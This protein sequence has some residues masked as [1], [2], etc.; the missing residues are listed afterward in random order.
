[1]ETVTPGG[2]WIRLSV[3]EVHLTEECHEQNKKGPVPT[4]KNS[5]LGIL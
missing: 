3:T 1:M 5:I 4:K 2:G